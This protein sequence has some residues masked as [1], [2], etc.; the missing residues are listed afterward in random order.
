M[1]VGVDHHA[2][3]VLRLMVGEPD[4]LFDRPEHAGLE[5]GDTPMSKCIIIVGSPTRLGQVGAQWYGSHWT[6]IF[7][8]PSGERSIAHPSFEEPPGRGS[9]R[10]TMGQ[11]RSRS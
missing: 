1:T 6:S 7:M 11:P 9:S 4:A 5:V 8:L 3:V 10:L 2:N